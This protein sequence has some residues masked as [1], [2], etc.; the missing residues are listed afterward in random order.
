MPPPRLI[1]RKQPRQARSIATVDDILEAAARILEERGLDAYNTNAVAERA[2]VSVGSLYQYFPSKDALTAA[3]IRRSA[4]DLVDAIEDAVA[5]TEGAGLE[6]GI[7]ELVSVAVAHQTRRP[8][9]ARLLDLEEAR[10]PMRAELEAAAE[11]VKACVAAFLR[12]HEQELPLGDAESVASDLFFIVRGLVD[13][14]GVADGGAL[15]DADLQRRVERAVRGYLAET[16][17]P[18]RALHRASGV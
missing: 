16:S 3:L 10:L 14:A 7:A 17:R 13:G 2:G 4:S 9:L 11:S 1:Q 18:P 8:E 5:K 15:A 6:S 12:R